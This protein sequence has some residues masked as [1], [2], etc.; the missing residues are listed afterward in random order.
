MFELLHHVPPSGDFPREALM[1]EAARVLAPGGYLVMRDHDDT[2]EVQFYVFLDLLHLIWYVAM[3]ET[4][5]PL[6]LIP[7]DDLMIQFASLGLR[8][9][10]SSTYP[11]P[12]PQRIYHQIL[13]KEANPSYKF[14]DPTASALIESYMH[15]LRQIE[16]PSWDDLPVSLHPTLIRTY[17]QFALADVWGSVVRDVGLALIV[18]SARHVTPRGQT[19]YLTADAIHQVLAS[20]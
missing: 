2:Q 8:A 9:V 15:H 14:A 12:N 19:Y 17:G 13:V 20:W 6:Y 3:D 7:R 4:S 10:G 11:E 5:D 16:V 18:E 1:A